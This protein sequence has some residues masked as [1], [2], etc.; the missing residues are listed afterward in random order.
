MVHLCTSQ[1]A[2]LKRHEKG[3]ARS[4]AVHLAGQQGMGRQRR[5]RQGDWLQCRC[6]HG[7]ELGISWVQRGGLRV[8]SNFD[9]KRDAVIRHKGFGP[10]NTHATIKSFRFGNGALKKSEMA[11]KIPVGIGGKYGVID[12][13]HRPMRSSPPWTTD[14]GET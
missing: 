6:G 10:V 8:R 3:A 12:A 11:A 13:A 2:D 1:D 7:S 5:A 14:A 9:R 4:L